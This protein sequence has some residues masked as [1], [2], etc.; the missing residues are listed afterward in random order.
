VSPSSRVNRGPSAAAENRAALIA[1][2][3][4]IFAVA[5]FDA[6]LSA[7]AKE[8]GV[9]QGSL[10][11]HF[12]DRASLALAVFDENVVELERLAATE[13]GSLGDLLRVVTD[14]VVVSTAFI[15]MIHVRQL[16]DRVAL[17]AERVK[18][19]FERALAAAHASGAVPASVTSDDVILA[20]GMLSGVLSASPEN[21]RAAVAE[22]VWSLLPFG[23]S[24][25]TNDSI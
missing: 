20:I 3:R 9:G 4:R 13:R 21:Q 10:Y 14:Q 11:R 5:G 12:P 22:R 2:A 7:V 24:T 16:D 17:F 19:L 25:G 18:G 15:E 6:P 8:A 23:P 1:A